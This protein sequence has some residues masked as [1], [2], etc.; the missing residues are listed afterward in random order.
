MCKADVGSTVSIPTVK[1]CLK[2][3]FKRKI[4]E[5]SRKV[6]ERH[7]VTF[8]IQTIIFKLDQ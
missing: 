3:S 8:R 2:I 5:S 4:L 1:K 6:L 7:M